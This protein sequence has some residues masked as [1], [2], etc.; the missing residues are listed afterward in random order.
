MANPHNQCDRLRASLMNRV[1]KGPP[2]VGATAW[3]KRNAKM[4]QR[5]QAACTEARAEDDAAAGIIAGGLPPVTL[6][7]AGF[8]A[9]GAAG[10]GADAGLT[11]AETQQ[12]VAMGLAVTGALVLG[13]VLLTRS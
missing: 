2:A 11:G 8:A 3:R 5:A 1:S 10:S 9:G 13:A 7:P 6:D 4:L 12:Y